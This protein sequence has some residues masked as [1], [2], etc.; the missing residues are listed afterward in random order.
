MGRPGGGEVRSWI[1]SSP[2]FD[3]RPRCPEMTDPERTTM[4]GAMLLPEFDHEMASTRRALERV[5]DESLD[6]RPHE[7]SFNLLELASHVANVPTWTRVTLTT[8][9]LDLD[10][11][12]ER[13]L[14]TSNAALLAEFDAN[15]A[16]A[17]SVLESVSAEDLQ[18]GWTLRSGDQVWFTQPRGAVYRS[19]VMNH[20][21][22]H[23]GQL[24]VYLRLLDV[25]VPGMYG[26]SADEPM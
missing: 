15:V 4:N 13:E 18:V 7:K 10:Q 12:F 26:P 2:I 5:P 6:F 1:L 24:T 8:T 3:R 16:D 19:F 9:E 23:R 17:R 20:L 11:P 25:P 22:H 21:I 14:P